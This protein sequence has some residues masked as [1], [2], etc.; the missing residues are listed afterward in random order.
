MVELLIQEVPEVRLY[1]TVSISE[2]LGQIEKIFPE[3]CPKIKFTLGEVPFDFFNREIPLGPSGLTYAYGS[4]GPGH[5]H[6][7]LGDPKS[8]LL[9]MTV[10]VNKETLP[11]YLRLL[12]QIESTPGGH[13]NRV[14]TYEVSDERVPTEIHYYRNRIFDQVYSLIQQVDPSFT[15]RDLVRYGREEPNLHFTELRTP[16]LGESPLYTRT[17]YQVN[18]KVNLKIN[19]RECDLERNTNLL[20]RVMARL[21]KELC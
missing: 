1:R 13:G 15:E 17:I 21:Y 20:L 19:I 9:S 11:N 16:Y 14:Q 4:R 8:F 12:S 6:R 10:S 7:P 5:D 3:L 18:G 2:F